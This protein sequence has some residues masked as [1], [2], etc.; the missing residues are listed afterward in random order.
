MQQN[1]ISK[2][3]NITYEQRQDLADAYGLRNE[4]ETWY[5]DEKMKEEERKRKRAEGPKVEEE[6]EVDEYVPH[7][8]PKVSP[9]RYQPATPEK[10]KDIE[11]ASL[12]SNLRKMVDLD[13]IKKQIQ[14]GDYDPDK[15]SDAL[16]NLSKSVG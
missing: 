15:L 16:D 8:K 1:P 11:S 10:T 5:L 14:E 6:E 2:I 13:A 7:P 9:Y 12:S 3:R 4:F